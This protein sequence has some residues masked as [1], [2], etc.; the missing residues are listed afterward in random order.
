MKNKQKNQQISLG[1]EAM[2]DVV[3]KD[4]VYWRQMLETGRAISELHD[5]YFIDPSVIEKYETF[6]NSFGADKEVLED[7]IF[8]LKVGRVKSALRFS[9]RESV[10]RNFI[11]HK[12][13]YFAYPLKVFHFGPVFRDI[14]PDEYFFKEFHQLGFQVVGDADPI[15][16]GEVIIALY[17]FFKSLKLNKLTL[18]IGSSGCHVCRNTFKQKFQNYYRNKIKDV[19]RECAKNYEI[20]PFLLLSCEKDGCRALREES[21]IIFDYL[22]TSC[23]NHLKSVLELVEDNGI[24]YEPDSRLVSTSEL[25]NRTIFEFTV[26]EIPHPLAFGCRYDYVSE[27]VFK[28]SIAAVGG[29][30]GIERTIEAMKRQSVDPRFKAKPK[31]FFLVIGDQAKKGALKLMNKLRLSGVA[32]V[33]MV[34][35]KT[36]KAQIKTAEKMG[37]KLALLL[38]QKE[39]FDGTI[40]LRDMT[41]GVQE[42]IL[43]DKLVEEV[44]KRLN[45][46]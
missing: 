20:N 36:L 46:E 14:K 27:A 16:D 29:S 17:D 19:C 18:K 32:V 26:P 6:E 7:K 34:G 11:D 15:Y 37:I 28:R 41:S 8:S 30:L 9:F 43:V 22:C 3:P 45:N 5:F 40:I 4:Q 35:K 38:G 24:S 39:V 25:N 33:E 44:K 13:A 1:V 10:L 23:N 42:T 2:P 31:V 21:P 12:L